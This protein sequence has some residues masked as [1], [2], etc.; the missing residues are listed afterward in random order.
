MV[1]LVT[2]GAGFIG[3]NFI[4]YQLKNHP[5]DRIICLDKLTY[6]GNLETLES[7][8]NNPNFR[9]VKADICDKEA[10]DKVFSEEK[11]DVVVNFAA[12]SHVD[13]S[14]NDTNV[15]LQT[16]IIGTQV[17]LDACRK[18]NARFHQIS[19]DEVYGDLP[20]DRTD[21]KFTE[22]TP[23]NPSSPYSASKAS[24]DLVVLSYYKTYGL[25][26][27]ITRCSNNYGGYQYPEK[28]IPLTIL[29]ALKN[30]P[31]PVYGNGKNVREWIY[32]E[33]HCEAV[34]FVLRNG[35]I[36]EIYNI[37]GSTEKSNIDVVTKVLEIMNKPKS[38]ISYVA[39]RPGHDR[40]YA[41]DCSKIKKELLWQPKTDFD[42]GLEHTVKWYLENEDWLKSIKNRVQMF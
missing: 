23:L 38:L 3:S 13:R 22:A 41:V 29:N 36:G 18:Y 2:G 11:P 25:P 9:F 16:N 20:I 12:E 15:F 34:D 28:L 39:D 10:V 14:I 1:L 42:K 5:E 19:T 8:K 6:A 7:V 30:K 26:V 24:A 32:V 31:V 33:D 21:L 40:R 27:T 35:K 37:G 4:F 17:L